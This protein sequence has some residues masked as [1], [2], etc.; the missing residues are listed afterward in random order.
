MTFP[1][2]ETVHGSPLPTA[3]SPTS[4]PEGHRRP[5]SLKLPCV[6]PLASYVSVEVDVLPV[7]STFRGL[8]HLCAFSAPQLSFSVPSRLWD[9]RPSPP[10]AG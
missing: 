5:S 9:S 4:W 7:V 8:C 6:T 3:R 10:G 1:C 2:S